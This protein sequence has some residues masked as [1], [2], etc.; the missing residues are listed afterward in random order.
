M[1]F[2][3]YYL[4]WNI[5]CQCNLKC[6]HC[7]NQIIDRNKKSTELS[8][9]EGINV[10]N[11]AIPLGLRAVL[12]TGGEPLLRKDLLEL[13]RFVKKNKLLVFLATNGTLINDNFINN[14]KGII[15]RIN[16]SLDGGSAETHDAIRGIEGS[17]FKALKS[18]QLV[19]DNFNT[20]I[21]FT[22]H[23]E[24]LSELGAVASLARKY[25][26]LLTIKRFIPIGKGAQSRNLTLS[27]SKYKILIDKINELRKNQKIS[28]SDPAAFSHK[29][30][31]NYYGGC[32]AGIYSLSMD[33]NGN[34]Y[35][36]TKLKLIVGNIREK[37]LSAIW[38]KSKKLQKLRERKLGGKCGKC[39]RI[40]SCGGCR[41]AAYARYDDFLAEDPLCSYS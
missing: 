5:T 15:N 31:K 36:C 3:L 18:I 32:L 33:F 24:N 27:K 12:F 37:S 19:K 11:Q 4:T 6:K 21:A 39:S 13:M 20:S 34:I 17:F 29:R 2:P 1:Q 28:F 41:A 7:Y 30:D 16:I 14:F 10:I 9:K 22:V 35:P 26:V 25:G 8:V 38:H 40:F 23:S